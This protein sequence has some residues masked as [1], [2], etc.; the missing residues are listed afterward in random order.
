MLKEGRRPEEGGRIEGVEAVNA[1][2]EG[3]VRGAVKEVCT[4]RDTVQRRAGE[5]KVLRQ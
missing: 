4:K 1:T 3:D 5:S 2:V